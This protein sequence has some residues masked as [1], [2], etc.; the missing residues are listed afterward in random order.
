MSV[1]HHSYCHGCSCDVLAE[2]HPQQDCRGELQNG[3]GQSARC[4]PEHAVLASEDTFD[5]I[6]FEQSC[7]SQALHE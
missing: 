4:C 3:S 7:V 6:M 5:D 2:M 1:L